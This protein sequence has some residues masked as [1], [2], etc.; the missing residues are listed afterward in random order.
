MYSQ[1]LARGILI[2]AN[3][4]ANCRYYVGTA[5]APYKCAQCAA[6]YVVSSTGLTCHPQLPNCLIAAS[7]SACQ[8][9]VTNNVGYVL[10]AGKCV[11]Y[12]VPNCSSYLTVSNTVPQC[13][14]CDAGYYLVNSTACLPGVVNGCIGYATGKVNQCLTCDIGYQLVGTGINAYCYPIDPALNCLAFDPSD[15]NNGFLTCTSCREKDAANNTLTIFNTESLIPI[16]SY[17]LNFTQVPGCLQYNLADNVTRSNFQCNLCNSTAYYNS[18]TL[19]C[20]TRNVSDTNCLAYASNADL[21]Q[22]CSPATILSTDQKS[23]IP[24][25]NGIPGCVTYTSLT[26]CAKCQVG[27]YIALGKCMLP[28]IVVANCE[29]YASDGMC[30]TCV[31]GYYTIENGTCVKAAAQNCLNYTD[32]NTCGAC[33]ANFTLQTS[34][35]VTSC[36]AFSILNCVAFSQ[37]APNNCTLCVSG[38]FPAG[39]SCSPVSATITNCVSYSADKVCQKCAAGTVLSA[40]ST[41]CLSDAATAAL[42][43]PNCD[44]SFIFPNNGTA[45]SRCLPGHYFSSS[46]CIQCPASSANC[47]SCDPNNGFACLV[48]MP[49]SSMSVAGACTLNKPNTTIL[50]P[51]Y[52]KIWETAVMVLVLI[53]LN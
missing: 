18:T 35:S 19:T 3:F 22:R 28:T 50:T 9:C 51:A 48:C 36:V 53:F 7:A 15:F 27:Y 40:D 8:T 17:C 1:Y 37:T 33:P 2:G 13:I 32:A 30:Q 41:Q 42:A 6:G 11:P 14:G 31:A 26:N 46:V 21:C 20:T 45:C 49:G 4:I 10:I 43:D 39:L 24:M 47:F 16:K 5:I 38:F 34:N 44:N 25:P 29:I 52:S 23:C 12:N